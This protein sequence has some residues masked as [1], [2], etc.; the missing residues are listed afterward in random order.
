MLL[1]KMMVVRSM[2]RRQAWMKWLPPMAVASPSPVMTMTFSSG[3]A[4]LMPVAKG[5]ARPWAVC[6]VLKFM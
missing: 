3:C 6:R 2:L 5:S 1:L 4:S